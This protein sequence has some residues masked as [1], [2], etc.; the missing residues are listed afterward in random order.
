[1]K[2]S[3]FLESVKRQYEELPYPPRNPEDEA[4]RLI[5]PVGDN[6]VVMNHFGFRGRKDF[7]SGF[8]CLVAGGGT[9]DSAIYL[10]QQLKDF[11]AEVV[12][13]DLSEPSRA[14][15][16]ERARLRGLGNI[17]WITDSIM[18]IPKLDIGRFD[19]INCSGVLHH[20]ASP[21]A[22]LACLE[23]V[24]NEDGVI[25]LMLYGTYARRPVYDMQALLKSFL[26][27]EA[28][29][30][31]KIRMTRKVIAELPGTNSFK[32]DFANWEAEMSAS[33][34]GDSGL[35][36]LLLHSQDRSFDVAQVHALAESANLNVS[37]FPMRSDRYDPATLVSDPGIQ[38][39]LG[40]MD[41]RRKQIL[42]EQLGCQLRVHE[43]YLSRSADTVASLDDE[44]NALILYWGLHG[45][46]GELSRQIT[47]G[48]MFSVSDSGLNLSIP[49]TAVNKLLFACMDGMTPLSQVYDRVQ[50][51]VPGAD[52]NSVRRE[53]E[54][55]YN[56]LNPRNFVY[57]LES[58]SYGTKV[59]FLTRK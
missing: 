31:E 34:F 30:E 12:Y 7:R 33:G 23:S 55:L 50:K 46:Q 11:D 1:L 43:V 58:G 56:F 48:Q 52:R 22:G 3:N 13:L 38:R 45:K 37:A 10:A 53:L 57:L 39:Y 17:R 51:E 41:T 9:G 49:G 16:E 2:R 36:D 44:D 42:A 28:S 20:L 59:P 24:L 4:Q 21:E 8:R 29:T 18:E 27:G 35:Y 25:F 47:P 14:I 19:F 32:R 26:P 54:E 15:A 40:G 5:H 6:L